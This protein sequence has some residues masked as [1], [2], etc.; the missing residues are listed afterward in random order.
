MCV[1]KSEYGCVMARVSVYVCVLTR[2]NLGV[3]NG[4]YRCVL[5]S[6]NVGVCW[7]VCVGK[8]DCGCW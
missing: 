1:G 2:M 6:V 8:G 7:Y 3:G 4:E 5:A